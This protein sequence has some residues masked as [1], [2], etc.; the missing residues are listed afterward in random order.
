MDSVV[1]IFPI[2]RTESNMTRT[3]SAKVRGISARRLSVFF[4]LNHLLPKHGYSKQQSSGLD[5]ADLPYIFRFPVPKLLS[6]WTRSIPIEE[7]DNSSP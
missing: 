4:M 7:E 1:P 6:N 2:S 3:E 5:F